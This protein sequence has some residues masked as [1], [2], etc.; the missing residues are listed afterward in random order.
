MVVALLALVIAM[1]GSAVAATL[2]TG[3]QIKD[4]T[5]QTRDIS[6]RALK[7]LK[8]QPGKTGPQ[9]L[10]GPKGDPGS[11]GAAGE[12]GETGATGPTG[13][14][15]TYYEYVGDNLTVGTTFNTSSTL[16]T[17]LLPGP[18]TY[19]VHA[20]GSMY[21]DTADAACSNDIRINRDGTAVGG[22][23][24][25]GSIKNATQV[26]EGTYSLT[27]LL[28]VTGASQTITVKAYRLSGSG[29]CVMFNRALSA[30]LVGEGVGT[31]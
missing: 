8:G 1:S 12:K 31:L 13:P 10:Q 21:E 28:S 24:E 17:L 22:F 5:I 2:I 9:G 4:H 25:A 14:S 29:N 11:P 26:A 18:A 19:L 16:N 6:K 27:R 15:K 7:A 20:D 23:A 3:R 30:T